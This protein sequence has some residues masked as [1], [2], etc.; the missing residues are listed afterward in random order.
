MAGLLLLVIRDFLGGGGE[1]GGGGL[2][3]ISQ[4]QDPNGKTL[5]SFGSIADGAES[6]IRRCSHQYTVAGQVFHPTNWNVIVNR[7]NLLSYSGAKLSWGLGGGNT[8]ERSGV[9]G[10]RPITFAIC[11]NHICL[12]PFYSPRGHTS[13]AHLAISGVSLFLETRE[14][15]YS[16]YSQIA[17]LY[18]GFQTI[19]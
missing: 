9:L 1:G 2:T 16:L 19:L 6:L 13:I 18:I 11:E 17:V 8:L 12:A 4:I 15:L 7:Q 14:A 3:I 5:E 10:R